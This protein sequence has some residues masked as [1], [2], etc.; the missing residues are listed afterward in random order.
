MKKTLAE[1]YEAAAAG[2]DAGDILRD[3]EMGRDR[4]GIADPHARMIAVGQEG[5]RIL[6]FEAG[7]AIGGRDGLHRDRGRDTACQLFVKA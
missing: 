7:Q 5:I 4:Y 6:L 1:F 3:I 2:N